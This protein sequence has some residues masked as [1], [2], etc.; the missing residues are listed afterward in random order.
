[1]RPCNGGGMGGSV[2]SRNIAQGIPGSHTSYLLLILLLENRSAPS[3][4]EKEKRPVR[5]MTLEIFSSAIYFK[6]T[7][8]NG[9]KEG[10]NENVNKDVYLLKNL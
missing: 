9:A 1:M 10:N 5:N 7:V 2:H 8:F 6:G 3:F 4:G